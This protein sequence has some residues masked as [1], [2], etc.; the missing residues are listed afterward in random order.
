MPHVSKPLLTGLMAALALAI[1]AGSA[2]AGRLS[3]D[4]TR[5]RITWP[6]L[7]FVGFGI[8]IRCPVT[9]EGSF[10]SSTMRKVRGALIGHISR[11]SVRGAEPPCTGGTSTLLAG[12]LP[13]H[14]AYEAFTG[15]LPTIDSIEVSSIG[16]A[17]RFDPAGA[18]HPCLAVTT[19]ANDLSASVSLTREEGGVLK[20]TSVTADP[21]DLI[22]CEIGTAAFNGFVR[23]NGTPTRLGTTGLLSIRLI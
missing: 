17:V 3:I 18:P 9:L 13:W 10:H 5:F 19:T 8:L 6:N 4:E 2:S 22:P 7:E 14:L 12:S 23:G 21:R 16:L 20:A 15:T 11:A 1:G